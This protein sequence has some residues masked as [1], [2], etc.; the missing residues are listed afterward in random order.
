MVADGQAGSTDVQSTLGSGWSRLR[1]GYFRLLVALTLT[2]VL[3]SFFRDRGQLL[4]NISFWLF[5]LPLCVTLW[6]TQLGFLSAAFLLTVS[7]ESEH[8]VEC[9]CWRKLASS[10]THGPIPGVDS[11]LGSWRHGRLKGR[12]Q[13]AERV[14]DRFPSGVLLSIS[15]LGVAFG[16]GCRRPQCLAERFG[17]VT[18]RAGL[19]TSG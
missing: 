5:L 1:S 4:S 6:R 11:A 7:V 12:M 16:G 17:A 15:R 3:A 14:L 13:G 18:A 9:R 2:I 19:I 10:C 8:A